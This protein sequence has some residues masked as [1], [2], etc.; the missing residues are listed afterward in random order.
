M[1]KLGKYYV[2]QHSSFLLKY[3]LVLITK[4]QQNSINNEIKEYLLEYTKNFFK[5]RDI[6]IIDINIGENY[7]R[8]KFNSNPHT[9]LAKFIN[10]FK[11]ASSR[12]IRKMFREYLQS[13]ND[14]AFWSMCYFIGGRDEESNTLAKEYIENPVLLY[15]KKDF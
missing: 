15:N 9:E 3:Q 8:I 7:M 13:F 10:A 14:S 12:N 1:K 6:E 5:N 4:G 2:N 11:S